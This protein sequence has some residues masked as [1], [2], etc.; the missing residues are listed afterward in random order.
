MSVWL[1]TTTVASRNDALVLARTLVGERL[2]ACA[3]ITAIESVYRWQG[4]LQQEG[5]FR[6]LFKTTAE[7]WSALAAA[8]RAR[9]PYELPAIVAV[10]AADADAAFAAWMAAETDSS[11]DHERP[12]GGA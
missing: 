11:G 12:A 5:E 8:L 4:A 3:Q 9:H 6:V 1:V 7:R 2:A 10:A